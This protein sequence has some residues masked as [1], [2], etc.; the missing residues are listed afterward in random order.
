MEV[1]VMYSMKNNKK[2]CTLI[3][4]QAIYK[5]VLAFFYLTDINKKPQGEVYFCLPKSVAKNLAN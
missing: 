5:R 3:K 1:T 4:A 2:K